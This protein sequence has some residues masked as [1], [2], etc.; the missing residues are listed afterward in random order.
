MLDLDEALDTDVA[1]KQV[2]FGRLTEQIVKML[3]RANGSEMASRGKPEKAAS[4]TRVPRQ[5]S[6]LR[7]IS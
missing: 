4:G 1:K 5:L 3:L 7:Q 2:F 6:L